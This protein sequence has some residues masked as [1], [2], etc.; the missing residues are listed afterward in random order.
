MEKT[1]TI[2]TSLFEND[3]ERDLY[4]QA[5]AAISGDYATL[6]QHLDALF[7]L[8]KPLD[9]F[10]DNVMV[11]ADDMAVRS[12]RKA[13]VGMIYREIYAIADIKNITL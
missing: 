9:R 8:K 1:F 5:T 6:E 7:A 12:N 4:A 11:N 10:F 2:D 13:L 3:A